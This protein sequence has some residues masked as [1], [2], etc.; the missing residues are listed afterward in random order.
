M[1]RRIVAL[2]AV[3][4]VGGVPF[5]ASAQ[6]MGGAMSPPP[7]PPYQPGCGYSCGPAYHV[8][9]SD[10]KDQPVHKKHSHNKSK[11]HG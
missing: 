1:K 4:I 7:L 3:L 11:S 8:H 9:N 2:A 6:G 5:P 10:H